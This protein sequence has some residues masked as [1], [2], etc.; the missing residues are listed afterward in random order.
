MRVYVLCSFPFIP[1]PSPLTPSHSS[2]HFLSIHLPFLFSPIPLA[3]SSP[4]LFSPLLARTIPYNTAS[5]LPPEYVSSPLPL[6]L[7]SPIFRSSTPFSPLPSNYLIIPL[8]LITHILPSPLFSFF[9]SSLPPPS[10]FTPFPLPQ[11]SHFTHPLS[12]SSHR[13]LAHGLMATT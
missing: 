4:D 9:L 2:H 8:S 13:A 1:S 3:L 12:S 11:P 6:I 5:S 7:T 10:P